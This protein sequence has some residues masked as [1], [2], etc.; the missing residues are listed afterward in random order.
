MVDSDDAPLFGLDWV[1]AFE[2]ALPN[3]IQ[4]C[5]VTQKSTP[6]T[7]TADVRLRQLLDE[8]ADTF[9]QGKGT[10]RGQE[11]VVHIDPTA[12]L[13]AFPSRPVPFPL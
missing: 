12:K 11:A 2:V 1:L 3:G 5:T 10:I 4:V 7:A 9:E 8:Y 13:R 6:T